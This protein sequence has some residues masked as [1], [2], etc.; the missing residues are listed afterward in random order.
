MNRSIANAPYRRQY[1]NHRGIALIVSLILLTLMSLVGAAGIRAVTK[2]EKM[3]SQVFDR[4]LAF[5]AAES[6]LREGEQWIEAAGRPTPANGAGC[7]MMGSGTQVMVCGH[8]VTATVPRWISTSFTDWA[9][10]TAVGTGSFAITP[11][12]FVE[13][14]GGTFPCSLTDVTSSNCKRYRVSARANPGSERASV[15]VQSIY[16]TYDP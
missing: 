9:N 16:A 6:A 12:Y 8:L 1:R 5:Q 13:Y 14:L 7:T 15:V 10:A 4:S 11:Q 2:E 3:V